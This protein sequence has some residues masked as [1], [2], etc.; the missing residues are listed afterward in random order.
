MQA[1]LETG[2]V[3]IAWLNHAGLLVQHADKPAYFDPFV[4]PPNPVRANLVLVTHEHCDASKV[5]EVTGAETQIVC[6]KNCVSKLSATGCKKIIGLAEGEGTV[7]DGV[8]V[9]AV[10][11][12]N[13]AKRFHPRG[14]GVGLVADFGGT[15]VYHAGDTDYVP[16]MAALAKQ[17]ISVA[18]LP[19]GGA[20]TMNEEE[21]AQAANAIA[22]EIGVPM[23]F[24]YLQQMPGD[25]K[26][27][28]SLV[29]ETIKV[30][31]WEPGVR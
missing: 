18:L 8:G 3:K 6:S 31:V 28:A 2:G 7:A 23:H 22:P 24:N 19:I 15:R 29:R 12:Y 16:E 10:P 21:A 5:K 27:F 13:L 17:K 1:S 9:I 30:V 26:K 11:A 4:L 14:L 25:A 20:Y